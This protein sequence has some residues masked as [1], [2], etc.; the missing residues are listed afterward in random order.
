MGHGIGMDYEKNTHLAK[1][2]EISSKGVQGHRVHLTKAPNSDSLKL[3]HLEIKLHSRPSLK[4]TCSSLTDDSP[5]RTFPFGPSSWQ[6]IHDNSAIQP[7]NTHIEP[8]RDAYHM[9]VVRFGRQLAAVDTV[10]G[11]NV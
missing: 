4:R 8:N 5:C 7:R 9:I 10:Q 2:T 3:S 11:V 6:N 1:S